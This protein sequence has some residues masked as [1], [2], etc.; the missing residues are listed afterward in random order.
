MACYRWRGL[1]GGSHEYVLGWEGFE[2]G[3]EG[4][5]DDVFGFVAGDY[6]GGGVGTPAAQDAGMSA[7]LHGCWRLEKA[8]QRAKCIA[9]DVSG[10]SS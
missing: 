5:A 4:G 6:E 2:C 10:D 9:V 8:N 1:W 3:L 7:E